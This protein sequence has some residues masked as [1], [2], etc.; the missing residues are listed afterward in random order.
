MSAWLIALLALVLLYAIVVLALL[1]AGMRL[2]AKELVLLVPNL[3]ILFKDLLADR[4]VPKGPKIALAIALVWIASPIDLIPEFIPVIG[5]LDDAVIAALALAYV[6]RRASADVTR[7]HW[8]GD[9]ATL[10]A[11]LRAA[12]VRT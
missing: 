9:P 10:E 5:S 4:R 3:V 12:G 11:I 7:E 8:R 1:L 2:A 6:V